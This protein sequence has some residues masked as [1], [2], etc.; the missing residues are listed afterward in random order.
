MYTRDTRLDNGREE[1]SI[2][3]PMSLLLSFALPNENFFILF[4][5]I[6]RFSYRREYFSASCPYITHINAQIIL[7]NRCTNR[8]KEA[9]DAAPW[10]PFTETR[11][12]FL[13]PREDIPLCMRKA[14]KSATE[15]ERRQRETIKRQNKPQINFRHREIAIYDDKKP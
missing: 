14:M 8:I 4:P 13:W 9:S 3:Y 6:L 15:H 10:I 12:I 2:F 1:N 5:H 7:A 11:A